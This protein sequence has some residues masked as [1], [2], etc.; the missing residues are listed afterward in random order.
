MPQPPD[1]GRRGEGGERDAPIRLEAFEGAEEA[2][3][4][5]LDQVLD[6]LTAPVE[7]ESQ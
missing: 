7:P 4:R 2:F 1:D 3:H 6:R 5:G